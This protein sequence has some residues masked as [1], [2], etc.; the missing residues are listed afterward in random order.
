M[1][2]W[3]QEYSVE[4]KLRA[5]ED[6]DDEKRKPIAHVN[7]GRWENIQKKKKEPFTTIA[8]VKSDYA[9]QGRK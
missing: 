7:T 1:I 3:E 9:A 8:D 5:E 6:D 2:A 4:G